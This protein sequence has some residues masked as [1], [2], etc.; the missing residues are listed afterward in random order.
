M[1]KDEYQRFELCI[2]HQTD[3]AVQFCWPG[4]EDRKFW[5][6][7]SQ[8]E[9]AATGR[10]QAGR[11]IYEVDIKEWFVEKEGIAEPL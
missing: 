5:V 7:K 11:T 1:A 2:L 8:C 9:F 10:E 3:R 4:L 6:P